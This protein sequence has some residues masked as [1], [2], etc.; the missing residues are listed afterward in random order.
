MDLTANSNW[1]SDT[2]KAMKSKP[3]E[4]LMFI[5][6]DATAAAK[7]AQ[8]LGNEAQAGQ[9]IDEAHYAGMELRKRQEAARNV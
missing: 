5:M 9:Y 2:M 7:C 4:S 1:H 8:D 3:I 6:N